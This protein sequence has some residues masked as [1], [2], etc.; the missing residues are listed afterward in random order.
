MDGWIDLVAKGAM[1]GE[2][3]GIKRNIDRTLN[4]KQHSV[5]NTPGALDRQR[6][7]ANS[8]TNIK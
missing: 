6:G 1:K 7:A 4:N 3:A 2:L 8:S 5:I